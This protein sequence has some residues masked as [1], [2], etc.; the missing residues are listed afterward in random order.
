MA[1]N[2]NQ[3]LFV[4]EGAVIGRLTIGEWVRDVQSHPLYLDES[5][6]PGYLTH[7]RVMIC[8]CSCG[9]TKLVSAS[10]LTTGRVKSCGCLQLERRSQLHLQ[11]IKT[12]K[13][14]VDRQYVI[15]QL[16][17]EQRLLKQLQI[18]DVLIRNDLAIQECASRIRNLI[19]MR[20][21]YKRTHTKLPESK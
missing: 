11:N 5:T 17:L 14:A 4:I 15:T 12:Q 9:N 3:R 1:K 6:K 20:G 7:G 18:A 16:R 10:I 21:M 8:H 19:K 13:D 2:R